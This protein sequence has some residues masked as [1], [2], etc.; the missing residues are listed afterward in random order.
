[1]QEENL[2]DLLNNAERLLNLIDG[3]LDFTKI[4]AGKMDVRLERS[5][6]TNHS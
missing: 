4:E 5:R 2:Q 6:L 1:L 3:L